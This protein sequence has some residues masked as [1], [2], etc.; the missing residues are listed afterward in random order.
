MPAI[1]AG[2]TAEAAD[3][4]QGLSAR[5]PT[6]STIARSMRVTTL[7]AGAQIAGPALIE[8]YGSTTVMFA[9]DRAKIA[10]TGE[11]IIQVGTLQ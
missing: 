10:G 6:A 8:E 4:P 11:I 9:G 3:D 5:A 2:G 1:Q 7:C